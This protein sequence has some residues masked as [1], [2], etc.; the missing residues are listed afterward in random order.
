MTRGEQ[1]SGGDQLPQPSELYS[2][3]QHFEQAAKDFINPNIAISADD[4][5]AFMNQFWQRLGYQLPSIGDEV[6][7]L[8]SK[9]E[10][11]KR[12]VPSL[13]LSVSELKSVAE[14][15]RIS[16]SHHNFNPALPALMV[17]TAIPEIPENSLARYRVSHNGTYRNLTDYLNFM[18]SGLTVRGRQSYWTFP[19]LD[20]GFQ[21]PAD[22]TVGELLGQIDPFLSMESMIAVQL[23]K[24][25]A[26]VHAT[27]LQADLVNEVILDAP[28]STEP[29]RVVAIAFNPVVR[30]IQMLAVS[31]S[32]KAITP[33]AT[34][35][36][37]PVVNALGP[38]S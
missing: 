20:I 6:T 8:N 27:N 22:V 9:V 26:G 25:A 35:G 12:L 13:L 7:D 30:Q 5:L 17:D 32:V 33:Y 10:P 24:Q 31:T 34:I 28:D 37:R 14:T 23:L 38:A 29:T 11:N 16:F 1:P 36:V 2:S 15:A 4:Q 21:Q 19:I 18:E 3:P